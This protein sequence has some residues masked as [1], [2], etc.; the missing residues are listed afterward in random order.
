MGSAITRSLTLLAALA[1]LASVAL[2][3]FGAHALDDSLSPKEADWW[4]AASFYLLTH[5]VAGLALSFAPQ[6]QHSFTRN[7]GLFLVLGAMIFSATL[8]TMALGAPTWLGAITPI[9]GLTMIIGW[10]LIVL[11]AL[12]SR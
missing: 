7:A 6:S 12:R 4:E 3:A 5:A 2:G 10:S 1:G 11:G 9:G 8:Y